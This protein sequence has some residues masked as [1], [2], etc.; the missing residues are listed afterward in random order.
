MDTANHPKFSTET[1]CEQRL[2][3]AA[4]R[5]AARPAFLAYY[6]DHYRRQRQ[7][8]WLTL[9]QW[10]ELPTLADCYRLALCLVPPLRDPER[11]QGLA[12]IVAASGVSAARL[13]VLLDLTTPER[14]V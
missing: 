12:R 5:A 10:L 7:W 14:Q 4:R 2:G 8:S 11:S 6:L 9:G 1:V 13:A 3:Y